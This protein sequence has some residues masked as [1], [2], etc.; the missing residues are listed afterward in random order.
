MALIGCDCRE[1]CQGI[2]ETGVAVG[3]GGVAGHAGSHQR[4]AGKAIACIIDVEDMVGI[5]LG[6]SYACGWSGV[7]VA[8]F[9]I[10]DLESA[11]HA[12]GRGQHVGARVADVASSIGCAVDA[13]PNNFPT[14]IASSVPQCVGVTGTEAARGI[15][16]AVGAIGQNHIAWNARSVVDGVE[17]T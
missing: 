12:S 1:D 7:V 15:R 3:V 6:A 10:G 9:A 14:H 8:A 2:V 13:P 17:I 5:A 4:L 16:Q 11:P